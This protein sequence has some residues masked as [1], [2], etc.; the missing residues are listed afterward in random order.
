MHCPSPL[1]PAILPI[2]ARVRLYCCEDAYLNNLFT[3][4]HSAHLCVFQLSCNLCRMQA[5]PALCRFLDTA[6]HDVFS[7]EFDNR[8]ARQ[9]LCDYI[10]DK[11]SNATDRQNMEH[12]KLSA[13]RTSSSAWTQIFEKWLPFA[14]DWP[15]QTP[16]ILAAL[17]ALAL[18]YPPLR[19]LVP[20]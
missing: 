20:L 1:S 8:A 16:V 13:P 14:I 4:R 11:I 18:I 10:G 5:V 12:K 17:V 15:L 19:S 3:D 6:G 9:L 7:P 2:I